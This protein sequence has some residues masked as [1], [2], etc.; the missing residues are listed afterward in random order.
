MGRLKW[1]LIGAGAV[2]IALVAALCV[3]AWNEI[4]S[5]WQVEQA[6]AQYALNHSPIDHIQGHDVFTGAGTEEVF[7]G[8]DAFGHDWYAFV[9]GSPFSIQIQS[10][11]GILS[12][13]KV[14]KA[15][16]ANQVKPISEHIGYLNQA[17]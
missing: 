10:A 11:S 3:G 15:A 4:S 8:Q 6:A 14:Q 1:W 2:C 17:A 7:Y 12:A 13:A 9:D 16:L 5:E